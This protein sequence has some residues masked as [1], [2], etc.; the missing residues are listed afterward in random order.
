MRDLWTMIKVSTL[1]IGGL[2]LIVL[3]ALGG[4]WLE[5]WIAFSIFS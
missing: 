3:L 1:V 5:Y 4:R 2:L